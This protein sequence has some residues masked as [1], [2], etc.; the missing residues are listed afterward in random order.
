MWLDYVKQKEEGEGLENFQGGH[1][2]MKQEK[3]EETPNAKGL[4][5]LVNKNFT[6]YVEKFEKHLDRIISCKIELDGKT[7]LQIMQVYAP[8]SDHDDETVEMLYEGLE[9]AMDKKACNHHIV[10]DDFNAKVGVRNVNENMKCIGPLGTGNRNERGERL[11][12][13]AEEN[14]LVATNSLFLKAANRYWTLEAQES[15]TKNQTD[16]IPLS[17]RKLW[18]IGRS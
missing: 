8:T 17:Y 10:M 11:L 2:C 7:S 9:K 1:G 5:L 13:F 16:F 3:T 12:E 14:N 6:G 4:A 18:E 15:V